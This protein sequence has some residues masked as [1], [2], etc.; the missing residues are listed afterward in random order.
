MSSVPYEPQDV[1]ANDESVD[2]VKRARKGDV[3]AI[4][5]LYASCTVVYSHILG[6]YGDPVFAKEIF[7]D[8]VTEIWRGAA[9]YQ[10]H[11]R[12]TTWAIGIARN[13]AATAWRKRGPL[14]PCAHHEPS[15]QD[16][17]ADGDEPTGQA[18]DSGRDP[19]HAIAESQQR[20]DVLRCIRRLSPKLG[21]VLLLVYYAEM[22]QADIAS[23]LE[24]NI[25]TV[26]T[27]VR[28][29]H[30]KVKA[31]LNARMRGTHE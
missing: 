28:D 5:Q 19:F 2:L 22:P 23:M 11:S 8:T 14:A 31:C 9:E 3:Q 15:D 7:Y 26:K 6:R 29:A 4:R 27:R 16:A 18:A 10:G 12:L 25:N 13:L 24:L 30:A 1:W 21:E 20:E 17:L